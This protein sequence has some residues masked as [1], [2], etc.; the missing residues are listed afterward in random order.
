MFKLIYKNKNLKFIKTLIYVFILLSISDLSFAKDWRNNIDSSYYYYNIANYPKA[1]EWGEKSRDAAVKEFGEFSLEHHKS[2]YL[3]ID[4]Y[5]YSGKFDK[6]LEVAKKDSILAYNLFGECDEKYIGVLN[7]LALLYFY[8][9]SDNVN[10][11]KLLIISKECL[12][13]SKNNVDSLYSFTISNLALVLENLG[14]FADAEPLYLASIKILR[15]LNLVDGYDYAQNVH[16]LAQLY[17]R[18]GRY[19]E[20]FSLFLESTEIIKRIYGTKNDDYAIELNSLGDLYK[21][22]GQYDKS[23]QYYKEALKLRKE[24]L[25]ENNE[26]YASTLSNLALL[27]VLMGR[28]SQSEKLFLKAADIQKNRKGENNP[29]YASTLN[30]LAILYTTLGEYDKAIEIYQKV[31][32]I[33]K[34]NYGIEHPFY[35]QAL[36]NLAEVYKYNGNYNTSD[37]LLKITLELRKKLIGEKHPDFAKTMSKLAELYLILKKYPLSE[38]YYKKA[39]KIREI[40]LGEEHP[41]YAKNVLGLA[42]L[43]HFWS[44]FSTAESFYNEALSKYLQLISRYFPYLSEKE[45]L[46][47]WISIHDGFEDFNSFCI[48]YF[49]IKP[50]II[51]QMYDNILVTKGLILSSTKKVI[52]KIRNSGDSSLISLL[53]NWQ[54]LKNF[55][56]L[57]MQ[58]PDKAK[59]LNIQI[60]SLYDYVNDLEKQLSLN[61]EDFKKAFEINKISWKDIRKVLE[62]KEAAIEI[63]RFRLSVPIANYSTNDSIYYAALIITKNTWKHPELVILKNGKELENSYIKLYGNLVKIQKI[64]PFSKSSLYEIEAMESDAKLLYQNFWEKI[65]KKLKGIKTVYLSVDGVYN[66]LNLQ[67]LINPKTN[68]Y[69]I[70][71]IDLRVVTNT[72]DLIEYKKHSGKDI[73]NEAVLFGNPKY[74]LDSSKQDEIVR[75]PGTE[76]EINLIANNLKSK[77]WEV[78]YYLDSNATEVKIKSII[79]P[80]ILHIATHGV[81]LE[82]IELTSGMSEQTSDDQNPLLRSMLYFSGVENS[83]NSTTNDGKLTAFEAMDLNLDNTDLVVLSA[84]ETGLGEVKNGEG[85]Y[86]LQRAFQVAGTKSLIMSLWTVSDEATQRLMTSF[87]N[88]L[89]KGLDKRIAFRKA[90]LDLKKDYPEFYFWGAFV[91]V[92]E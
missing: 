30:N 51:N 90:Q 57:L 9:L 33:Y 8:Y 12:E 74:N 86:G 36:E 54:K 35:A 22:T 72:K 62:D 66:S 21:F 52:N 63:I 80:S 81:F 38:E 53:D 10:A 60:D 43:Y 55:W 14:L 77:H 89:L 58:N 76:V 59:E 46:Q 49:K 7:N 18:M 16:N 26:K 31:L 15:K 27:Y 19:D 75:L 83:D 5:F 79:N 68:K 34:N 37:S 42:R 11:K 45:K 48:K 87:Y 17:K 3:L 28:Y 47:F 41:D 92:G 13:N 69:L 40:K 73:Q 50:E 88:C 64:R 82:D 29:D 20:A 84:C 32:E 24:L 6:A 2:L 23:E 56:L 78:D 70:E 4:L 25:G 61:S 91:M 65:T 39:I 85:V 1:L 44:K 71:E 67:T